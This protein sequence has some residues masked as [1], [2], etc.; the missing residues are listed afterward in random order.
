MLSEMTSHLPAKWTKL[1]E[2]HRIHRV[3]TDAWLRFVVYSIRILSEY[4]PDFVLQ[5]VPFS[6]YATTCSDI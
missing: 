4:C 3:K 5:L 2:P 1:L 6:K